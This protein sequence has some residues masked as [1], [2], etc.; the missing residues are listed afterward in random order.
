MVASQNN[1]QKTLLTGTPGKLSAVSL[2]LKF[3]MIKMWG[4][5]LEFSTSGHKFFCPFL[6]CSFFSWAVMLSVLS[7]QMYL[8]TFYLKTM[9]NPAMGSLVYKSGASCP[10]LYTLSEE[11]VKKRADYS[12][13]VL[14]IYGHG[15]AESMGRQECP[16]CLCCHSV[17]QQIMPEDPPCAKHPSL[18]HEVLILLVLL[19]PVGIRG[20]EESKPSKSFITSDLEQRHFQN[21]VSMK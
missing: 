7:S 10:R 8:K 16:L 18:W 17:T 3:C 14:G 2:H 11:S 12:W 4:G 1:K 21:S 19:V 5:G 6:Y 20:L 9:W 15:R 13:Q